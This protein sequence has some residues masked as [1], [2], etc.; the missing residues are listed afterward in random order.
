[1][2]KM[3]KVTVR[4]GQYDGSQREVTFLGELLANHQELDIPGVNLS[5][6][7]YDLYRVKRGY[8]VFEKRWMNGEG[9]DRQNYAKLSNVLSEDEL[10]EQ[11]ALVAN[12]AGIFEKQDLDFEQILESQKTVLLAVNSNGARLLP[13]TLSNVEELIELAHFVVDQEDVSKDIRGEFESVI[14]KIEIL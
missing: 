4:L 6:T 12:K 10:L 2:G 11:F 14:G 5:G 1:M 9:K 8:R 7:S 3:K 13:Y